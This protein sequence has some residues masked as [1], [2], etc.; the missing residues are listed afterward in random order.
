MEHTAQI[1]KLKKKEK[2]GI[3]EVRVEAIC[4]T[5]THSMSNNIRKSESFHVTHLS[6]LL[7]SH[8]DPEHQTQ[9]VV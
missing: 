3:V 2:A 9:R 8:L 1:A 4:Y 7:A 5:A 6:H